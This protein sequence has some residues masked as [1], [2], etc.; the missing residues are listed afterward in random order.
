MVRA[1]EDAEGL[2]RHSVGVGGAQ[3][4]GGKAF[5]DFVGETVGRGEG[6]FQGG[7]ISD[8]RAIEI[9]RGERLFL[10]ELCD[11]FGGPVDEHDPDV[12]GSQDGDI[13]QE[14]GEVNMRHDCAIGRDHEGLFAKARNVLQD[15]SEVS[16]FHVAN[17]GSGIS[18]ESRAGST[19]FSQGIQAA[20]VFSG[21]PNGNPDP[22]GE[23]IA[24]H[25]ARN[26]APFLEFLECAA[27]IVHVCQNEIGV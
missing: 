24:G 2:G 3:I 20:F 9:A 8:A 26:D 13:E 17:I 14:I 25:R 22:F 16:R 19:Q 10:G 11:L 1:G 15:A 6:Q 4:V 27:A 23:L 7:V 5:E 12:Q 18:G 21:S